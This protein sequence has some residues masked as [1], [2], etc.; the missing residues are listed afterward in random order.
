M[1][2]QQ[3]KRF[4]VP[5]SVFPLSVTSVKRTKTLQTEKTFPKENFLCTMEILLKINV[6]FSVFTI[7]L[8]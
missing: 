1:L 7:F 4:G 6:D 3:Q 2:L 8:L 5:P